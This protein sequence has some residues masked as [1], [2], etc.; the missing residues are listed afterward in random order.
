MGFAN[1]VPGISGGTMILA[2]GLYG[3]FVGALSRFSRLQ[4]RR[5]DLAFAATLCAGALL[6]FLT[7]SSTLVGLVASHRYLMYSLFVGMTLGG[8]PEVLRAARP[9]LTTRILAVLLGVA[10]MAGVSFALRSMPIE[11]TAPALVLVGAI[12]AASM[13][14]PGISGSYLLLL[15][16]L[17]ETIIGCLSASAFLEDKGGTLAILAPFGLGAALGMGLL[18]NLLKRLLETRGQVTHAL[19]LGLMLGSILGLWPFQRPTDV[20]LAQK[21]L[22][23]A[24]VAALAA[25]RESW[26]ELAPDGLISGPSFEALVDRCEGLSAADLKR[27]GDALETFDPEGTEI[28][29]SLLLLCGGVLVTRLA[30]RIPAG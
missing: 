24:V 27:A 11:P 30:T 17:Y 13:I 12:A 23:K 2:M 21:P 16:G 10:L 5:Q 22:R 29:L 6:A 8:G 20:E 1:L 19:L 28:L 7:L 25:P 14:L 9:L 4:I 15:F 18:S 3:A 26:A